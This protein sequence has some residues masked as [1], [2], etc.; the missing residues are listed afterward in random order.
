MSNDLPEGFTIDADN[1]SGLPEGFSIDQPTA[2]IQ[3]T[4]TVGK[5]LT[6]VLGPINEYIRKNNFLGLETAKNVSREVTKGVPVVGNFTGGITDQDNQSNA[7]FEK[8]NPTTSGALKLA[9]GVASTLP[10]AAAAPAGVLGQM[11]LFSGL[12]GAD[13]AAAGGSAQDIKNKAILGAL[14]GAAGP[15]LGKVIS[16]AQKE[17]SP[18]RAGDMVGSVLGSL[19]GGL[20]GG[21][22]GHLMADTIGPYV[23]GP[24]NKY[25]TNGVAQNPTVKAL[26]N[27]L[28]GQVGNVTTYSEKDK[29]D[30]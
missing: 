7:Q 19:G 23:A 14:G 28:G 1:N 4:S 5:A 25:W 11:G 18:E 21:V 2:N 30:Q 10:L 3:P 16:P 26:L 29:K 15:F 13:A 22:F 24:I 12:G 27:S 6:S 20:E 17:L 8:N 9:G